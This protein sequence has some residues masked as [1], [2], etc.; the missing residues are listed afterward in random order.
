MTTFATEAVPINGDINASTT[1]FADVTTTD[2]SDVTWPDYVAI[3]VAVVACFGTV[4]NLCIIA[5]VFLRKSLRVSSNAFIVNLAVADLI[6]TA[7]IMP[8]GIS[9]SQGLV[10]PLDVDFLCDFNACLIVTTCGV[11][12]QSL[13][14]IAIE[15]YL[16]VCKQHLHARF[17]NAR[18]V[19]FAIVFTWIYTLAFSVQGFTGWTEYKLGEDTFLCIFYG[20]H[21]LSYDVSLAAFGFV[22]PLVVLVFCYVS[23]YRY[24]RRSRRA[25]E[26]HK[27]DSPSKRKLRHLKRIQK[28]ENRFLLMLVTIVIV[29]FLCW[30]PGAVVLA[31]SGVLGPNSISGVVYNVTIWVAL[32]N[33]AMNSVIYGILNHNFRRGYLQIAVRLT[34]KCCCCCCCAEYRQK[35]VA[36]YGQAFSDVTS[37]LD[38]R[39]SNLANSTKMSEASKSNLHL[40]PV[41]GEASS[42]P[43]LPPKTKTLDDVTS[44]LSN[45]A[46]GSKLKY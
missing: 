4:G 31:L 15:R 21:S 44:A 25:L 18:L 36:K 19:C 37:T 13:M 46:S 17:V 42:G 26:A 38:S 29:F 28:R 41:S 16:H 2:A 34:C 3:A 10:S 7:Y 5:A 11:S 8:L 33:S 43:P 12:T 1:T 27:T 30:A 22:L 9:T 45:G 32:S 24:I 20:P 14:F 23:I 40:A 6:V 35:L 39:G